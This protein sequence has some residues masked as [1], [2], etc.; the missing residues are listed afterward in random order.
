MLRSTLQL[1]ALLAM[2]MCGA[3]A[4]GEPASQDLT[5]ESH[6]APPAKE[7]PPGTPPHA[8][9]DVVEMLRAD[10]AAQRSPADG[11]GRAWLEPGPDGPAAVPASSSRR[12]KLVYEVGPLGIATHGTVYLQVSPFWGWS[13]PQVEDTDAP[14]YTELSA[15]A[16]DI[17]LDAKTLGPQLLAIE[18]VG[19]PLVAGERVTLVYGASEAGARTDRFAE[20]GSR[21]WFAVDGDGDGVRG[22]LPDSPTVDVLAG[23]PAQLR[24]TL[25]SVA[26]PGER[27]P[28]TLAL[29][30]VSGNAGTP[31]EGEIIFPDPP[32]GLELPAR[33]VLTAAD[34]GHKTIFALA[35]APGDVR[36][37]AEGPQGL[38]GESNPLQISREGPRVLWADLHGHSNL[39]DGTGTPEDYYAYARDI[40]GLDVAALTDHD[41]WGMLPLDS[42]PEM[43]DEIE[44]QTKAFHEPGRFVTLLGYEWTSW[45]QGHRH[46]LHFDDEGKVLSSLDPAYES[47]VQ[48]WAALA[49]KPVLTF[50]HH[51]AGGPVPTNWLIPPDPVLE[52][53]TEIVSVHGSSEAADSPQPIYD[54]IA[55]NFVRG[56]ALGRGYR[57]GFIGS[58]DSHDGHPGLA[59]LTSPVGGLAA[60]L[61]EDRTRE[62][63]LAALRARRVYAT[64]GPR[65]L[66][67]CALGAH[68]MG[69]SVPLGPG[70]SLSETLFVSALTPEP[71]ARVD[72]IRSGRVVDSIELAGERD[73]AL[74]RRI[75]NLRPG[76]YV[77]VRVV[78][79][80]DGTAWSSPI[81]IE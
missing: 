74:E 9:M 56:G 1:A 62:G 49:G 80:D 8:R 48:L 40:A 66:L 47:P 33:V 76:E 61:S 2:F 5:R 16:N 29:L 26:R 57:F 15:S 77:Y 64:S 68:P 20:R 73:V 27:V 11:G 10:A 72:L 43:W 36:L 3:H 14:G 45:I 32:P 65:I 70:A 12:F 63:V 81:Y 6:D 38:V 44:R 75:E 67:R 31:A 35:R 41:H 53:I 55:D 30:D 69:A 21:F 17:E 7:L 37:R 79:R 25:P 58:G 78:Q 22:I 39:S 19:R 24:V 54:P 13:T 42:H 46:V 71:L 34:R 4:C 59:Q 51:S 60:I 50:A 28:V 18:V 52:P 23:P